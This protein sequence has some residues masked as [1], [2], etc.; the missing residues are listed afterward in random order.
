MNNTEGV[1]NENWDFLNIWFW[2][3]NL[4]RKHGIVKIFM[5]ELI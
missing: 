2:N 3:K 5:Y 1:N 4:S